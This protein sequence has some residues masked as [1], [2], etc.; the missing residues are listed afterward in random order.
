MSVG[1]INIKAYNVSNHRLNGG[2]TQK[3][4]EF[5]S[6]DYGGIIGSDG[7]NPS[8]YN[9]GGQV[10]VNSNLIGDD[11]AVSFILGGI[12]V[13]ILSTEFTK[14]VVEADKIYFL[15]IID[16]GFLQDNAATDVCKDASIKELTYTSY[17]N[18]IN[19]YKT[20]SCTIHYNSS[21]DNKMH[22]R[23]PLFGTLDDGFESIVK[24][25]DK[26]S[27]LDN[28]SQHSYDELKDWANGRFTHQSGSSSSYPDYGKIG[29][30]RINN[31]TVYHTNDNGVT[32]E[33]VIYTNSYHN[34]KLQQLADK[35][36]FLY[37]K[38]GLIAPSYVVSTVAVDQGGTGATDR[39]VAKKNLG[40]YYGTA[41]PNSGGTGVPSNPV[42]G[43]VYF[44]ILT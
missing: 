21:Y 28:L 31:N 33:P 6:G 27:Y 8:F 4:N 20:T 5:L 15:D 19:T 12:F 36:G 26:S 40:F 24:A 25:M 16:N 39:K 22:L 10:S 41:D 18:M 32:Y 29:Y 42:E 7:S 1:T 34:L 2:K 23:V 13:S 30:Y 35:T 44:R 38:E 11:G 9:Y 43:D 37:I 14:I 17:T 3:M